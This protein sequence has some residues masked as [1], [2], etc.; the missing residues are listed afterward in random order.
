MNSNQLKSL[1]YFFFLMVLTGSCASNEIG[2]SRDVNQ[3]TIYQ[4]YRVEYDE[5]DKKA[6]LFAQFRFAGEKGTTLILS[7]PSKLEFNTAVVKVDSSDF[8]GAF[9]RL[10]FPREKV[11]GR[12]TLVY[13]DLNQKKYEN[14]FSIDSFYLLDVP[15]TISKKAPALIRFKA[16]ALQQDDYIELDSEGTDSSFS[17]KKTSANPGEYITI[18]VAELQRQTKSEIWVVPTLYR[19]TRLQQQTKEGGEIITRQTLRPVQL[20]L[21][22][23]TL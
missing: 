18:P 5:N 13:T 9:Y 11:M 3:E 20:K 23:E 12:H 21:V 22:D 1:F 7:D 19:T 15:A 8:S 4:Q 17:V 10:E 6:S 2:E 16:P 14:T